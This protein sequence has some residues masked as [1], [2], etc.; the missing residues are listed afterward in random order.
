MH[1]HTLKAWPATFEAITHGETTAD[2]RAD[3]R[4]PRYMPGHQ[5]QYR[6]FDNTTGQYTGHEAFYIIA[7]VLRPD[8]NSPYR[9]AIKRGF[10]VLILKPVEAGKCFRFLPEMAGSRDGKPVKHKPRKPITRKEFERIKR[11]VHSV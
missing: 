4:T 3:D 1:I 7:N 6:Q 5:I 10:C 2:I 9:Q 11:M 8:R